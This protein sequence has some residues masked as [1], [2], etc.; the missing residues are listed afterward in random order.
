[1]R[2]C[3]HL[4]KNDQYPCY[5]N[6]RSNPPTKVFKQIPKSIMIRLSTNSLNEDIFTQNKQDYEIAIEIVDIKKK[7]QCK[8][9]EDIQTHHKSSKRKILSF[10]PPYNMAVAT[11]KKRKRIFFIYQEKIFLR[12]VIYQKYQ[13]KRPWN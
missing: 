2:R 4:E 9:R 7:L 3:P 10:N 8:S 13:I 5:I 1:M 12:R 6:V 11:K